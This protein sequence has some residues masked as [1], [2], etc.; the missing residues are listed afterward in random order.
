[1]AVIRRVERKPSRQ[2]VPIDEVHV[3]S[4]SRVFS[5]VKVIRSSSLSGRR[6][7]L[8][9]ASFEH[10]VMPGNI[11]ALTKIELDEWITALIDLRDSDP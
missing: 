10:H 9:Q 5:E 3:A 6:E 2:K 4:A 7:F 1:M 11:C 8:I